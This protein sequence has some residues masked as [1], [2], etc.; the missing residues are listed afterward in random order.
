NPLKKWAPHWAGEK[1]AAWIIE[2][3]RPPAAPQRKQAGPTMAASRKS[4]L[5]LNA[6]NPTSAKPRL[7]KPTS[8][9]KGLSSHPMNPAASFP[10]KTCKTKLERFEN[11][12]E[13]STKYENSASTISA[14]LRGGRARQSAMADASRPSRK[15][16]SVKLPRM[17]AMTSF[18]EAPRQ[19]RCAGLGGDDPH[20]II[21]FVHL[22][23]RELR[24][25]RSGIHRVAAARVGAR[26]L[27]T[28]QRRRRPRGS[29]G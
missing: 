4:K 5:P 24:R 27:S 28:A 21:G 10:K 1:L 19:C 16:V 13:N 29:A 14:K 18:I 15:N 7:A 8:N 17:N 6:S 9:W 20:G 25:A 26:V 22:G 12:I 3:P 2:K 11:P 23:K